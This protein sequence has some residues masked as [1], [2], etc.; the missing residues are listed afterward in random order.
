M[1]KLA[2]AAVALVLSTI[3]GAA[4]ADGKS[5]PG[6][7]YCAITLDGFTH[8]RNVQNIPQCQDQFNQI[9]V[10]HCSEVGLGWTGWG[11]IDY[12]YTGAWEYVAC[13]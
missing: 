12:G 7:Q 9:V 6:G 13:E 10:Q 1:N 8:Y 11:F 2:M 5:T 4:S 3:P